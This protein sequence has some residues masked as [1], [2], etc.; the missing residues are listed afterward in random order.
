MHIRSDLTLCSDS[1]LDH[2]NQKNNRICCYSIYIN[3]LIKLLFMRKLLVLLLSVA[4]AATAS[5]GLTK[6]AVPQ[7]VKAY[8]TS[9]VK[10]EYV[11]KFTKATPTTRPMSFMAP[12]KVDVPAGYAAIIVEAHQV[13]NT[14]PDNPDYSGYQMLIDAD[15]TAYGTEFE[16]AGGSGTFAGDYANFE[17]K[18][19]ENADNDLETQ[20]I[21]YDGSMMIMIPAGTYDYVFV[22][23][24]PG[25]RLWIASQNG[26]AGGRGDDFVFRSRCTYHFTITLGSN[27][28]DRVD[29]EIDDPYATVVPEISVTPAATSA[30]V[31]WAADEN[32]TGYNLRWRP[33]TPGE[34]E[35]MT[36]TLPYPGY[37]DDMEGVS[38][39]DV[40]GDGN[41]WGLYYANEEQTDLCVGS[42][43]YASGALTPDNWLIMPLFKLQGVLRFTAWNYMNYYPEKLEVMIGMEDAIEDNTV[44]TDMFTTIW[45][46]ELDSEEPKEYEID[47]SAYNGEMGYIVFR[48]FGTTDM[49][50]MYLDDIFIGTEGPEPAPWVD[51]PGL[52]DPY[53]NIEGLTPE[54]TYEVQVQAYNDDSESAWCDIV[55]F[56]TLASLPDVYMIGGDDQAW[57]P[58]QGTLFTYEN[59]VYTATINFPAEYNYFGFTTELAENNDDGGWAYI[60]P[61]RFGAISEGD[62]WY[63][64]QEFVSLTWDEYHAIRI[65]GGEYKLTVDLNEMKLYIEDLTP[66]AGL[67]GDVNNDNNV[68]IADVTAL[69]DYLLSGDATGV[70]LANADCNLDENVSISDVT[71]LIDYLLSGAW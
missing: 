39:L 41:N 38:I 28:N 58:T 15:A 50:R 60:E 16:A 52:T 4:V 54:T 22:N 10:S 14:D 69:I 1:L 3:F 56:T 57:D 35:N 42:A 49:Y 5:A 68:S 51:V 37:E 53:H 36:I 46:T 11:A 7:N 23:P 65:A 48:H 6:T 45:N 43:S 64:G 71:A 30:Y 2:P 26:N 24:T 19:P 59:G 13:W 31:E 9:K 34:G 8:K 62:F 17:Y 29:V 18:I 66:P 25:D 67:R 33:F 32:A 63:E 47:L 21:V 61:F 20:N 70:N 27:G 12:S 44:Y 40:D 55:Q